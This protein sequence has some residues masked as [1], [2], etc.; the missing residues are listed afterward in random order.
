MKQHET[1]TPN[2]LLSI[3][4]C[5]CPHCRK[6]DMFKKS[7]PYLL[8]STLEMNEHCP[9]CGLNFEPEIGFYFGTGYVSYGLCIAF[10]VAS[11]LAS[12]FLFGLSIKD[13]SLF[14]WLGGTVVSL[15]LLQPAL[16]RLS[17]VIW[18]SFFTKYEHTEMASGR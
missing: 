8:K 13:N 3:V 15:I 14:Y 9:V 4:E 12:L 6:G 7:N 5:K 11:F 17:R 1:K 18:L 10:T 16:M 2:L